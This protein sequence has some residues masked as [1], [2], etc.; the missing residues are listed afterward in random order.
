MVEIGAWSS[1][2]PIDV[3]GVPLDRSERPSGAYLIAPFEAK[4]GGLFTAVYRMREIRSN[5]RWIY[6]L[7]RVEESM[8]PL[9]PEADAMHN[10]GARLPMMDRFGYSAAL[11]SERRKQ[12]W[13]AHCG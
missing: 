10:A 8:P 4:N 6:D 12:E 2:E 13:A 11:E 1:G 7:A 5:G 9:T 3:T